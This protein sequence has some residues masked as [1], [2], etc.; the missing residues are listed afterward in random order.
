MRIGIL[1]DGPLERAA[2]ATGL[3]PTPYVLAFWGMAV[4]R[5]V[6]AGVRLGVFEALADGERTAAELAAELECDPAG[7]ETLCSALNGFGFLRHRQGRYRNSGVTRRFLLRSARWSLAPGIPF[8]ADVW[9]RLTGLEETV[10]TG[11]HGDFHAPGQP[12]E[13][14]ERYLRSLASLARFVAPMVAKR[15]KLDEPPRRLLDVGGGHGLFS[16][17][18]C[19]RWPDLQAEVLDLPDAVGP[20][21]R[22]VAE[23]GLE[24][25]VRFRAGDLREDDLGEGYDLV[26]LFNVIHNATQDESRQMLARTLAA[27]RPGGT[28]AVLDSEHR[29]PRGDV[30]TSGG[31]SEL[32]CF[33]LNGTRAYPE[34]TIRGWLQEA[35]FEG[36]RVRGLRALQV[37]LLCA[38]RPLSG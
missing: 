12:A 2:L 36:I 1:P 31:F 24:E 34:E 15:I 37:V 11:R 6:L 35:G 23:E 18:L 22:I 29:R 9:D 14:W 26:L 13:F 17:A 3:V 8:L 21:R 27:L 19:R 25:R 20:G 38:R 32:F 10:R 7:V 30:G 5:C 28:V 4:C 33:L 16:V